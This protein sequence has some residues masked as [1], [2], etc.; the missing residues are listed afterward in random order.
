M[1]DINLFCEAF[2]DNMILLINVFLQ[3]S[4]WQYKEVSD[5][6][7]EGIYQVI[8][9]LCCKPMQRAEYFCTGSYEEEE[10]FRHYALSVPYYTHFTSPIRRYADI[11]VH[12]LLSSALGKCVA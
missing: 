2:T 7:S 11:M 12:R 10:M 9:Q 5:E 3:E 4:I 1:N 6:Q 8:M